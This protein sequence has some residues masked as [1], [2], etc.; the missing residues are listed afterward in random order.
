MGCLTREAALSASDLPREKVDVPEWGVGA[1]VFVRGLTGTERDSWECYCL[2][3]R[4][5]IGSQGGFPGI[6]ASLVV[7]AT[8]DDDGRRIFTDADA[9]EVSE[10]NGKALDRI[11]TVAARL[12]G[13]TAEDVEELK[14][15]S[16]P[17]PSAASS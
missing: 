6:R 1:Y 7:R 8:I 4:E 14:K 2:A 16:A 9:D 10:K 11:W 13:I 12:S 3:K 17:T 5:A 15:N